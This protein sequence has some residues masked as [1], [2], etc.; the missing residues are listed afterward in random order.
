MKAESEQRSASANGHAS[1]EQEE[2]DGEVVVRVQEVG[3]GS[4]FEVDVENRQFRVRGRRLEGRPGPGLVQALCEARK[5]IDQVERNGYNDYLRHEYATYDDVM[6]AVAEPMAEAGVWCFESVVDTFKQYAGTNDKGSDQFL[7]TVVL[8]TVWTDG[9]SSVRSVWV[10]ETIDTGDK[11]HYQLLSQVTKYA[12]AKTLKL[13]T[14][15]IDVD[16]D[17]VEPSKGGDPPSPVASS[18][19]NGK[20]GAATER[21]T[22]YIKSLQERCRSRGADEEDYEVLGTVARSKSGASEQIDRLKQ[23]EKTLAGAGADE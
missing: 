14:G 23:L 9:D 4:P 8:E 12:Y 3:A 2:D 6:R 18:G 15:D 22:S 13:D 10:G 21:Q 7:V 11:H 1:I 5:E 17:H 20:G 19:A 16:A